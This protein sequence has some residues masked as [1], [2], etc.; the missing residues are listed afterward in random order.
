M[1]GK[2]A[3]EYRGGSGDGGGRGGGWEGIRVSVI[4]GSVLALFFHNHRLCSV[5]FF[6]AI[7][8]VKNINVI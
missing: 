4:L 5:P 8:K 7:L 3:E 1:M 2:Q 6:Y